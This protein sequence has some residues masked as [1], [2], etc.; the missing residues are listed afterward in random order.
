[1]NVVV[2]VA[3][4]MVVV[5]VVPYIIYL[6]LYALFRPSG[7]P[8]AKREVEPTV[9]I[10]LPTYNEADIIETK[11]DDLFALDYPME[12]LEVVLADESDDGTANI[13]RETF[14]DRSDP[15]LTVVERSDRSGVA[16]SVNDAVSAATGEVIF[17]TDCDSKLGRDVLREAVA[18]LADPDVGV[19]TGRQSEVI[20]NSQVEADYRDILTTIQLLESHLDST[21]I[22]HGPCMA[23]RREDF[24][25][26][27]TDAVADDTGIAVDARRTG[28]RVVMD[29]AMT[30]AESGVSDIRKRRQRKDRRAVGLV[31]LLFRNRD[32]L[33]RCDRYGRIV[34]PFNWWFMILSPWLM[35]LDAVLVSVAAVSLVGLLGLAV[36]AAMLGFVALGSRDSLGP[37]QPLYA[38]VDSQFSLL[39]AG[40]R[41]LRGIE[42]GMWSVDRDSRKWFENG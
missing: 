24:G 18:N 10:V 19:V 3:V 34:L 16:A 29:P 11:L 1:M 8:A 15:T 4:A 20:G 36:P 35:I 40:V 22:V 23:F 38:V 37:V 32:L 26:L 27:S 17:R 9:S 25:G 31:Q 14:E 13:A 30:F 41:L 21:F 12:K 33:G 6:G 28:K 39:V 5:T 7:S 2:P 42:D